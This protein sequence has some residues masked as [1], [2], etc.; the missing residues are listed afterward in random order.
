MAEIVTTTTQESANTSP[1][2]VQTPYLKK[3]FKRAGKLFNRPM[4]YFP[5]STVA[6]MGQPTTDAINQIIGQSQNNPYLAGATDYFDQSVG[7]GFLPT[8]S[9][10]YSFS[11]GGVGGPSMSSGNPY[12]DAM[13]QAGTAA[14][15]RNF[16]QN[17]VPGLG[18]KFGMSG[19]SGSPGMM[20][21]LQAASTGYGEGMG[22]FAADLYG[23]A[24]ENERRR[25]QEM[26]MFAPELMNAQLGASAAGLEASQLLDEQRQRE[27]SDQVAR[28][29]FEQEEPWKRLERYMGNISGAYGSNKT[30]TTTAERPVFE[31]ETWQQ[32]L[33][34][35]T[36]L[37]GSGAFG[38]GGWLGGLL[39]AGLEFG[40]D[41]AD[42]FGN[43]FGGN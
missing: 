36:A 17:V 1:W 42:W 31:P 40:G 12:L 13:Y 39:D 19:R 26:A 8:P 37:G 29:Q 2:S 25:Q 16:T 30:A 3:G 5:E 14:S 38:Q 4:Q 7:G 18:A 15:T 10:Q 34:G 41:A 6:S 9:N 24:Y 23:T 33:G 22:N 28:F 20:N 11:G 21:A 32:I 35:V 27:L 43:L